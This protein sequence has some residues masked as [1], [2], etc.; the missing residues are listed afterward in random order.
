[1]QYW[2]FFH[3]LGVILW[4]GGALNVSRMLGFH[5]QEAPETI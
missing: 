2:L 1:M 3:I 5:V 4:A